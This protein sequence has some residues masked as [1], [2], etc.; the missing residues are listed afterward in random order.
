MN[1]G[2]QVCLAC[3][4]VLRPDGLCPV[5]GAGG[6]SAGLWALPLPL[7]AQIEANGAVD[8]TRLVADTLGSA[9]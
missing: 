4:R 7:Q 2:P 1:P 9:R 5:C 3:S 8:W 6:P